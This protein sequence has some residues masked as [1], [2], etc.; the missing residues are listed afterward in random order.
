MKRHNTFLIITMVITLVA[1]WGTTVRA[2]PLSCNAVVPIIPVV[3]WEGLTEPVN[4]L[5]LICTG[6]IAGASAPANFQVFFNL[7]VTSNPLD[8]N[9]PSTTEALLLINEPA[10]T[11]QILGTNVFRGKKASANSL[12]WV[13][14]NFPIPGDLLPLVMHFTNL[15]VQANALSNTPPLPS[16]VTALISV[17]GAISLPINNSVQTVGF[18]QPGLN[19]SKS[20][21]TPVSFNLNFRENFSAAFRKRIEV[22]PSGEPISQDAPFVS[23]FTESGFTTHF[24]TT[25]TTGK[26]DTGTRLVARFKNIPGDTSLVVPTVVQSS[27]SALTARLL[28]QVKPDYSGGVPATTGVL[29]KCRGTAFAVW[30]VNGGSG[31]TGADVMDNFTIPV[32]ILGHSGFDPANV[33]GNLGPISFVTG[34]D[35]AAPEP[36]FA[37]TAVGSYPFENCSSYLPLIV[38]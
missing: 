11:A 29:P 38:N 8:N 9:T 4:D 5:Y 17:S 27:T 25:D 30:E 13:G 35:L 19:F 33:V 28:H 26:A 2:A 1:L 7:N 14:V 23:Y 24:S 6:G 21:I 12:I 34:G 16:P 32:A 22:F 15:R 20:E 36:R 3:R 18:V 31:V 37:Y 10:P